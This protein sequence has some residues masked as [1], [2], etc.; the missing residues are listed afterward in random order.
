MRDHSW[1][2]VAAAILGLGVV[3]CGVKPPGGP[4]TAASGPAP[5]AAVAKP[6]GPPVT[7]EQCK[8]FADAMKAAVVGND[9]QQLAELVDW[10]AILEASTAD[11]AVPV[12]SRKGFIDG[13]KGSLNQPTGPMQQIAKQIGGQESRFTFLRVHDGEDGSRRVMFR[14]LADGGVNYVDFLLARRP[15]NRVRAVDLFVFMSSE[16]MSKTLRR[17]FVPVAAHAN[18]G[19]LER[20]AGSEGEF[21]KNLPTI[22]KMNASLRDGRPKEV[23]AAY[24]TLPPGLRKD[25]NFQ[26]MRLRAA[27]AVDEGEY[28]AAIEDLRK[29]HPDDPCIDMISIDGYT[30]KKDYRQA[31]ACVDRLDKA[32][33]GDP[34]L[35]VLRANLLLE[36][37][38]L[39]AADRAARAAVAA[40]PTLVDAYWTRVAVTLKRKDFA[41]TA[42]LLGQITRRF[43][44]QVAD[45]TAQ[46]LYAEFVKSPEYEEWRKSQE[47]PEEE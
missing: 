7:D 45:L 44:I 18:R 5:G 35:N 22:E 25:K 37:P 28:A 4:A 40:E 41:E 8:E 46:P 10:D 12:A 2:F 34:Y 32:I 1:G 26:L 15:G 17:A 14:I 47:K 38:D 3:G 33:G 24:K 16:L 27:Q 36:V 43:H 20:L 11:F 30:F 21:M 23:L 9:G 19:V 13:A 6:A 31:V 42:R 39:D 29:E